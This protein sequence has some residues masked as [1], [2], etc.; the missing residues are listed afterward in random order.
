MPD[1]AFVMAAMRAAGPQPRPTSEIDLAALHAAA[2]RAGR[3]LVDLPEGRIT[4]GWLEGSEPVAGADTGVVRIEPHDWLLLVFAAALR[5]CWFDPDE[6]PYPGRAVSEAQ[7]LAAVGTLGPLRGVAVDG[8]GMWRHQKAALPKLRDGG[9]LTDT[10]DGRIR[11]G[12]RV[13]VWSERE[14][15][16]LGHLYEQM[17]TAPTGEGDEA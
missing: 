4:L 15:A 5:A 1:P 9:Y 11:L 14:I 7:I 8:I 2:A 10:G 17:P 12:P 6:H 3:R 13:A 16:A